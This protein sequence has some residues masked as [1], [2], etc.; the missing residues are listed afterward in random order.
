MSFGDAVKTCF[1][2]YV[3]FSGRARRREFWFWTL[4]TVL[5][6]LLATA[7][8]HLLGFRGEAGDMTPVQTL[9][10]LAFFLPAIAVTARRLHDTGRSGWWQLLALIPILG[11]LVLL[12]WEV[13]DS[14]PGVNSYGPN[15]KGVGD[16]AGLGGYPGAAYGQPQGQ[17]YGQTPPAPPAYGQPQPGTAD[18]PPSGSP[19]SG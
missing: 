4:F 11:G 7:L 9:A 13:K 15:P 19:Y 18:Q 16:D 6:S 3:D 2:K 12:F 5:V 14:Q 17:S 1:R 8:D 10:A